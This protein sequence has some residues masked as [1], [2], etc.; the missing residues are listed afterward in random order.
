MHSWAE[1]QRREADEIAL[2][3][4]LRTGRPAAGIAA[5]LAGATK[6]TPP[7]DNEWSARYVESVERV[8]LLAGL[9]P[10]LA[11]TSE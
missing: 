8:G 11:A 1:K 5:A 2:A 4:L 7:P 10:H 3:L 6:A 9:P